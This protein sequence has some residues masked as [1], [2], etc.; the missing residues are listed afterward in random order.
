MRNSGGEGAQRTRRLERTGKNTHTLRAVSRTKPD[1]R[2]AACKQPIA[3]VKVNPKAPPRR[4]ADSSFGIGTSTLCACVVGWRA[5]ARQ[6]PARQRGEAGRLGDVRRSSDPKGLVL[7]H[8]VPSLCL[9][10]PSMALA[11]AGPLGM[12]GLRGRPVLR[13]WP[14]GVPIWPPMPRSGVRAQLGA[15]RPHTSFACHALVL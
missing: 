3:I 9:V 11:N 8:G 10:L 12:R 4:R 1:S 13:K 2:P 5:H 7:G 6:S 14:H 15:P